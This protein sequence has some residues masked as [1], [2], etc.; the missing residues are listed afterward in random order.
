MPLADRFIN[1]GC[2]DQVRASCNSK[3]TRFV[4]DL[5]DLIEASRKLRLVASQA[6]TVFDDLGQGSPVQVLELFALAE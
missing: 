3:R 6:R 5:A 1:M 2:R 4:D